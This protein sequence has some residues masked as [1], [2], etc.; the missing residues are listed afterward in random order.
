MELQF[1]CAWWGLDHLGIE[2]MVELVAERGY[3]GIETFVPAD[4][5]ARRRLATAIER[6]GVACIAH[7]YEADGDD[8][9]VQAQLAANLDRAGELAPLLVNS[10]T[11]RDFWPAA[12]ID[13]LIEV[14]AAAADRLGVP[15]LHETHR[16]RFPYS[17]AVTVDYLRRHPELRLT[18]DLSHW[19]C[20]SESLLED[21]AELL[22]E[23][24]ERVDHLHARVGWAQS[25]QVP[26]PRDARWRPAVDAHVGWWREIVRRRAAAGASSQ[27]VTMEWGPPPYMPVDA[28]SGEP[29]LD[30]QEL[31]LWLRELL[32]DEL[33]GADDA[34]VSRNLRAGGKFGDTDDD[35]ST[36][37]Q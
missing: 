7:Q 22:D 3:D 5:V 6:A 33:V 13:P 30:H 32:R 2:A 34:S 29:T 26:D 1:F 18:A 10:H 28:I 36:S 11:G 35:D 17:A 21:Q 37:G 4:G 12:R 24:F 20:V 14:A 8:A 9:T 23:A 19:A 31:N 15:V 16:S 27:T 25:A